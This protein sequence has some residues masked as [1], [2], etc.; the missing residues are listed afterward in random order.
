[1]EDYAGYSLDFSGPVS[2]VVGPEMLT[3]LIWQCTIFR[4]SPDM[5]LVETPT[6]EP[7]M[8]V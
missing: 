4:S 6:R 3:K 2:D 7:G 8:K 1:M 5:P